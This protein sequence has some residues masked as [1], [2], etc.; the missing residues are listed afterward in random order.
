MSVLKFYREDENKIVVEDKDYESSMFS[1]QYAKALKTFAS[2]VNTQT[3]AK[4][5]IDD[6]SIQPAILA[7]CGDR[8]EGK[9]SCLETFSY[10]LKNKQNN[11]EYICKI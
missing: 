2:L 9:S 3:K 1:E 6:V 4:E 7:F 11:Q 10:I 5:K 8:G